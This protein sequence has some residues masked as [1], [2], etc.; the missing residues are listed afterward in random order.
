MTAP[1]SPSP[2]A[3]APGSGGWFPWFLGVACVALAAIVLV[4]RSRLA[5]LEEHLRIVSEQVGRGALPTGEIVAPLVC[6]APDGSGDRESLDYGHERRATLVFAHNAACG[7][8]EEV[9]PRV[10]VLARSL[11]G[12][13]VRTVALQMDA[14]EPK[15]LRSSE[16]ATLVVRGVAMNEGTWLKRIVL[17][18]SV[19]LVDASGVVRG[20]WYGAPTEAQWAQIRARALEVVGGG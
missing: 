6:F 9:R 3:D 8:C 2:R 19:L 1:S 10:A 14:K 16:D 20:A 18:P 17:V 15:D 11:S 7:A 5:A 4:Q 12:L 13:G